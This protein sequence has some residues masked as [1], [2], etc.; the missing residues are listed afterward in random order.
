[1]STL[2][3]NNIK[4]GSKTVDTDYILDG[5]AKTWVNFN[6]TGTIATRDSLNVSSLTD[7]GVGEYTISYTSTMRASENGFSASGRA[8]NDNST[9]NGS[10]GLSRKASISANSFRVG[11]SVN[12]NT[13]YDHETVTV[14]VFGDLA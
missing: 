6:G 9:F 8:G 3:A 14:N 10:F 13:A 7:N 1:M 12:S 11:C 5:C 2:E 4:K